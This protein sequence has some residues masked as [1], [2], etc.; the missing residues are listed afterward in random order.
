MRGI[1][2][3]AAAAAGLIVGLFA[4]IFL[5]GRLTEPYFHTSIVDTTMAE[6]HGDLVAVQALRRDEVDRAANLLESRLDTAVITLAVGFEDVSSTTGDKWALLRQIR[7]YRAQYPRDE[8]R[9]DDAPALA[10]A[11]QRVDAVLESLDD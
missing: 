4:G 6:A 8:H 5:V 3:I 1:W 11:D 9:P 2:L 7:D 10:Q